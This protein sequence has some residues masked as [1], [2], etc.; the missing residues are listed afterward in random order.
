[1]KNIHLY[2]LCAILLLFLYFITYHV[3]EPFFISEEQNTTEK[4]DLKE[5]IQ[6]NRDKFEES[7]SNYFG[8]KQAK[9]D[10]NTKLPDSSDAVE[11]SFT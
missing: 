2:I 11:D 5:D 6:I 3:Q 4:V 9:V 1:M 10:T 7:L 8:M